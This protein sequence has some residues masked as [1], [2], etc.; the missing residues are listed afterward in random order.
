MVKEPVWPVLDVIE[1]LADPVPV[2][3]LELGEIVRLLFELEL[4]MV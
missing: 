2:T 3:T 4:A 1:K